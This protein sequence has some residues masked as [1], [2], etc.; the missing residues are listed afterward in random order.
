MEQ[1]IH[2]TLQFHLSTGKVNLNEIV[3]RL[4]KI[5]NPLMRLILE[6]ILRSYD[7]LISERLSTV[8]SNPPSKARKGLGRHVR[9]CDPKDRYCHGRRV[10]KRGYRSHPRRFSTVFGK[11]DLPIR[12]VECCTCGA[13]YSPLLSALKVRPYVRNEGQRG[14]FGPLLVLPLP[15]L[16]NP[17]ELLPTPNGV[18]SNKLSKSE[19]K[20]LKYP[21]FRSF[22]MGSRAWI[23]SYPK[24]LSLSVVHGTVHGDYTTPYG[25]MVSRKKRANRNLTDLSI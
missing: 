5:K 3:Y 18:K 8:Q 11:L 13:R 2:I 23:I 9:K 21:A 19:S 16:W 20:R 25:R 12:V 4:Q 14:N 1:Q 10:R 6:N 15:A 22:M 24:L 17:W 7:D